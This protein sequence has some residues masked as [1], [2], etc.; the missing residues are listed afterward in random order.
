MSGWDPGEAVCIGELSPFD[1]AKRD[2]IEERATVNKIVISKLLESFTELEVS[3]RSAKLAL[4]KRE[5]APRELLERVE[6]YE[7]ILNKQR[8][9]ADEMWRQV[10]QSNWAEVARYVK[11]INAL[12][13]MIRDD[14]REV[15]TGLKPQL[16]TEEREMML[17]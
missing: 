17:S 12:S 10:S 8:K 2:E 1:Q 3:I 11:L 5:N 13:S 16:S 6:N 9:L 7:Q 15:V 4:T 14:A